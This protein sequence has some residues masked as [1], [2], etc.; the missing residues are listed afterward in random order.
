MGL[1][2]EQIAAYRRDG[3]LKVDDV[4]EAG[5]LESLRKATDEMVALSAN[6]ERSDTMFD[7]AGSG[8]ARELRR[9]KEPERHRAAFAD[10]LTSGAV[11]DCV[12]ALIGTDLRFW[13]SKLNLKRPGGGQAVEWHQ[14]W[15]FGPATNDDLLTVGI[16]LDDATLENGCLLMIPGSHRDRV[17]DHWRDG[18]FCGAVTEEDFDAGGAVPIE[19]AARGISIH[20]IRT[21]HASAVN[22]SSRQRR[23]LLYTYAA[24][25]AW[26]LSGVADPETFDRQMLHGNATSAPRLEKVPVRPWPRWQDEELGR[27]TS[28]F[29]FQDR[30]GP[31]RFS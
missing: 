2:D 5:L 31:S 18:R 26:P 29:D 13:A 9:I 14:D 15:A 8:E 20:H 6:V 1:S 11:L 21:L 4:I 12:Q 19:V 25:D 24:A 30:A 16:A 7:F 27:E 28:L 10:A 3:Y 22:H 17:L 23:L